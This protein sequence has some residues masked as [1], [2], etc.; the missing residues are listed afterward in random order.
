[1]VQD[2]VVLVNEQNEVLGTAD[3]LET[4]N[5]Q[6]PLHRGFSVFLFDAKGNLLL[7]QRS[8]KKKTWPL[9]W[10]NSCCGHPQLDETSI[11]AAKRRLVFELGITDAQLTVVLPDYRYQFEKD[12]IYENEFCP[13]MIGFT[14]QQPKI[15]LDEVAAIKWIP[16]QDW[17]QEVEN[18]PQT[19]SP[20]CV[21]ETKLLKQIVTKRF[22]L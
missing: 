22:S 13:V 1:M 14:K 10:S 21:E 3:K 8:S 19:Y 15:N 18:N 7:Q 12:G 20:W 6:T 5:H 2:Y 9:V 11:A 17:L 16:W 4:H